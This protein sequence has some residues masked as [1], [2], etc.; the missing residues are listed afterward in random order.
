[1]V[2]KFNLTGWKSKQ[3]RLPAEI[4]TAFFRVVQE[5]LTN[6]ALH[7]QASRVDILINHR[8]DFLVMTIEDDGIGFDPIP[9]VDENR[10]GLFGMRER[11]EMLGGAFQVESSPGKGTTIVVEV[12]HDH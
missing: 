4:E 12:P 8:N 1:M 3:S 7:A 6:V 11:I 5:S 9:I 10:L 2:C